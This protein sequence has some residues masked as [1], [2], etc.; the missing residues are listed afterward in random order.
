M[1]HELNVLENED[2]SKTGVLKCWC[3]FHWHCTRTCLCY[4][5]KVS[6]L[7]GEVFHQIDLFCPSWINWPHHN[8]DLLIGEPEVKW[9]ENW[10]W[11]WSLNY[12]AC[13]YVYT[14]RQQQKTKD[15]RGMT[16]SS[17]YCI[18]FHSLTFF[19]HFCKLLFVPC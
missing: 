17:D 10:R 1:I 13:P 6:C 14:A 5:S 8:L 16:S 18:H 4:F 7:G 9:L 15:T 3:W 11:R 12:L 2:F 19:C